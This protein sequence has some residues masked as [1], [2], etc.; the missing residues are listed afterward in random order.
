VAVVLAHYL[1]A[2]QRR[3]HLESAEF[4]DA[5]GMLL[6]KDPRAMLLSL[7]K[8]IHEPNHVKQCKGQYTQFFYAWTGDY[9]S[10]DEEDPEYRRLE[11]LRQVLGAAAV[12]ERQKEWTVDPTPVAPR[13]EESA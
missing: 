9:S 2:G 6:L 13:L 10:N 11:R 5:Q 4:A 12:G 3:A 1:L 8:V 7:E